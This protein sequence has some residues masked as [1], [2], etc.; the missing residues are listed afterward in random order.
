LERLKLVENS[1]KNN[2]KIGGQGNPGIPIVSTS[3]YTYAPY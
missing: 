3:S 2:F 1:R